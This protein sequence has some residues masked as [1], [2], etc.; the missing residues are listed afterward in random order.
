MRTIHFGAMLALAVGLVLSPAGARE[1]A[2]QHT[3]GNGK[4]RFGF[5]LNGQNTDRHVRETPILAPA[6]VT[7][8]S[9]SS[10]GLGVGGSLGY[11]YVFG[12]RW[13]LGIEADVS[14]LD[15]G[16]NYLGRSYRDDYFATA[17]G[18][19]GVYVNPNWLL[20]TTVGIGWLGKQW[21]DPVL[22]GDESKTLTGVTV[23]GGLEVRWYHMTLFAEYL[24]AD[25]GRWSF[26]GPTSRLA[27]DVESHAIRGGVKFAIGYDYR[28]DYLRDPYK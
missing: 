5:F 17:R 26:T 24:Y 27:L 23:G 21:K 13:M 3:E 16:T 18:R 12:H 4:I 6:I 15:V 22:R 14:L 8:G 1:A 20:Y 11:D 9:A 28:D 25:F 2:A 19:F 10:S 7:D